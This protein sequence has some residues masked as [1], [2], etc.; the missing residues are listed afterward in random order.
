LFFSLILFIS[1]LLFFFYT[2][3]ALRLG[4]EPLPVGVA[5]FWR[6][7]QQ[8]LLELD[9]FPPFLFTVLILTDLYQQSFVFF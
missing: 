4:F 1:F 9:S 6:E 2:D 7:F 3:P 8:S 5:G